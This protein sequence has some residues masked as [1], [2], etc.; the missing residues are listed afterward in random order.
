PSC[1]TEKQ[2]NAVKDIWSGATNASGI[3]YPGYMPGAEAAGGW[4]SYMTGNGPKSGNHWEQ[5]ANVLKYMVFEDPQWDFRTFDYD[6]DVAVAEGKLGK[7][8]DAFDPALSRFRG[9]KGKPL[10]YQG[11]NHPSISPLN[12]IDYYERVV[13]AVQKGDRAQA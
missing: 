12:T 3:V 2:I 13:S 4:A 9:Q 6:K 10:P 1:L 11:W 8:L 5:S 7:T